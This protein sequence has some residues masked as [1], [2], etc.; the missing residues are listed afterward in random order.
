MGEIHVTVEGDIIPLCGDE[1]S[2]F[3]Q[4]KKINENGMV[5]MQS[6]GMIKGRLSVAERD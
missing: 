4:I 6:L 2:A 3:E 5:T 1:I